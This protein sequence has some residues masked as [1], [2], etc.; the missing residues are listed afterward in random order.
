MTTGRKTN[1][2]GLEIQNP[3]DTCLHA[4]E[5]LKCL[6]V[7][8]NEL[9]MLQ[10][11][12]VLLE[13][14]SFCFSPSMKYFTFGSMAAFILNFLLIGI[15]GLVFFYPALPL[16]GSLFGIRSIDALPGDWTWPTA[17][18]VGMLW[19]LSFFLF[20]I[21]RSFVSSLNQ[22]PSFLLVGLYLFITCLVCSGCWVIAVAINRT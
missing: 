4:I 8:G 10:T 3:G 5:P 16:L 17:V 12:A 11:L 6:S 18:V 19:S 1:H 13:A 2:R 15:P 7:S 14:F 20:G 21:L 9:T 22:W